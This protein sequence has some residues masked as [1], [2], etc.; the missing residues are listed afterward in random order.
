MCNNT[1]QVAKQTLEEPYPTAV[2]A[3][4]RSLA[5]Y[6]CH[7][8]QRQRQMISPLLKHQGLREKIARL[9]PFHARRARAPPLTM[10]ADLLED[11]SLR[12]AGPPASDRL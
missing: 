9:R 11:K 7:V 10:A 8:H 2:F 3:H 1:P 12:P 4:S 6:V 5:V